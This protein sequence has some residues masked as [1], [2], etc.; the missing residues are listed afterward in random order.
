VG[1]VVEPE[2]ELC[3]ALPHPVVASK[4]MKIKRGTIFRI[5]TDEN[6]RLR[7]RPFGMHA[8][9]NGAGSVVNATPAGETAQLFR[10]RAALTYFALQHTRRHSE[11]NHR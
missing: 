2:L 9:V 4:T 7:V 11:C 8:F 3:E 1:K 10:S 5:G 6:S